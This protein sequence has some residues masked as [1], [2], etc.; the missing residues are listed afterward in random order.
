MRAVVAAAQA[1]EAPT[2]VTNSR[3]HTRLKCSKGHRRA[4]LR[5]GIPWAKLRW[6]APMG[7]ALAQVD[8][9]VRRVL[10]NSGNNISSCRTQVRRQIGAPNTKSVWEETPQIS[11]FHL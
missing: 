10:R 11:T 9:A 5:K 8:T 6:V 1:E 7:L 2:E 4:C 3:R